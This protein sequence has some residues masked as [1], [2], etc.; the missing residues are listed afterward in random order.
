MTGAV[1][2]TQH[3]NAARNGD[4]ASLDALFP[5]VYDELRR[6]ARHVADEW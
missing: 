5:V 3:L 4:T 2:I 1:D 6:L